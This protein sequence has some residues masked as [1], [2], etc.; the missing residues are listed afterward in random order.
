MIFLDIYI[1]NQGSSLKKEK[2]HFLIYSSEESKPLSTDMIKSFI[3]SDGCSIT[4][5]SIKLAIENNIPIYFSDNMGKIYGKIWNTS[6]N[7]PVDLHLKQLKVF[8]SKYGNLLGRKWIIEKIGSQ[9]NHL[10]KL[11]KRKKLSFNILEKQFDDI[12]EKI[13]SIDIEAENYA[14]IIMGYEGTASR[15]YYLSINNFLPDVWKFEKR[16]HQGATEPYN[17]I[18][19]YLFGVLYSKLDHILTISGLNSNIGILHSNSVN[20]KSLLFDFIEPYRY[21]VWETTFGLFSKKLINK[22]FFNSENNRL[23]YEGKKIILTEFYRKMNQTQ[24]IKG[25]NY[26]LEFIILKRA[27]NLVKDLN[28]N[29]I[30]NKL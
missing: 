4:T 17:I 5:D 22:N 16:N 19:N 27:K 23:N 20:Q 24:E 1:Q 3:I 14:N 12:I 30:Y 7:V 21:I 15:L 26:K 11:H 18:L 10:L 13:R 25:K 28:E 2:E 9:K 6:Y 8:S 29:E